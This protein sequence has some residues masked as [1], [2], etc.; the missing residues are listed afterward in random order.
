M[1]SLFN[2]Q[3]FFQLIPSETVNKKGNPN[4]LRKYSDKTK[5]IRVPL[6][7]VDDVKSYI[8][9]IDSNKTK[10]NSQEI[11]IINDSSNSVTEIKTDDYEIA[12][13]DP[14]TI[15]VDTKRFQFKQIHSAETGASGSLKG[16]KKWDPIFAGLIQVWR[17]PKDNK[18]Y[19]VNGHNRLH[20]AL[21]LG[22][23][24][25]AIQFLNC[26]TPLQARIK[27]ALHNMLDSKGTLFD[28]AKLLKE[29]NLKEDDLRNFGIKV[30]D[31]FISKATALSNLETWL[32]DK[33]ITGELDQKYGI[34]IGSLDK[35]DQKTMYELIKSYKGIL[36]DKALTELK[37]QVKL[38]GYQESNVLDMF[39]N[40]EQ[41]V[42]LAVQRSKVVN[43]IE[44]H[45]RRS[46]KIFSL[47][48]NTKNHDI[49]DEVVENIDTIASSLKKE[50]ARTI[51]DLFLIEKNLGGKISDEINNCVELEL[52]NKNTFETRNNLLNFIVI[53][54]A[55]QYNF[56]EK[57]IS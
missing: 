51:L 57:I 39:G 30:N 43:W 24:T 10:E 12:I 7:L 26:E 56:L 19:V 29:A 37:T 4:W 27:G 15:L 31:S 22:I 45:L 1:N 55:T 3:D 6:Y 21:Q 47:V 5:P 33:A 44:T 8:K 36:T 18:T 11:L 49:L 35:K 46:A 25:I 42:N 2:V 20:L 54:L 9:N 50:Q 23:K 48:S 40:S 52:K 14:N 16:V 32:F 28:A 13:V 17:D 53:F 38:S 34:A 41:I